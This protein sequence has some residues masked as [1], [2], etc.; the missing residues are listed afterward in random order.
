MLTYLAFISS[1][2]GQADMQT[3]PLHEVPELPVGGAGE[4]TGGGPSLGGGVGEVGSGSVGGEGGG[5]ES[6]PEPGRNGLAE[7]PTWQVVPGATDWVADH[8]PPEIH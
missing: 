6:E 5:G 7:M 3:K 4:E 2:L 8:V 1:K